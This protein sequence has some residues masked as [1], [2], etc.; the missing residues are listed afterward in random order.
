MSNPE[1]AK[2]FPQPSDIT[3]TTCCGTG[4]IRVPHALVWRPELPLHS[5]PGSLGA[6]VV[7]A[8]SIYECTREASRIAR[9]AQR[10]VAFEFDISISNLTSAGASA[11]NGGLVVVNPRDDPDDV[12]RDWWIRTYG[13]TPWKTGARR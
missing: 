6:E 4:R 8:S 7:G 5:P 1:D 12:A 3:C 2:W 11:V 9:E 13:E 10:P